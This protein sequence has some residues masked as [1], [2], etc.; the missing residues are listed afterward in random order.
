[1]EKNNPLVT[2][3]MQNGDIIKLELYPDIA[4]NTVNNFISLTR[5]GFYDGLKFHRV[6]RGFMIQ[7]GDP[8]GSGMGGPGYS[9]KGE[10]SYNQFENNVKH[11]AGVIS[12]ARSQRPNSAGSQ[13]FI[14]HKDS[15]HLDGSY[16]A[17]GKVIEGLDN[18]NK[19]AETKTDFSD[20]PLEPQI[21]K[22]V[23]VETFGV[24]YPEPE[25]C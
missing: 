6:I 17:F 20:A 24:D 15:P 2:I 7:G 25:T 3:E 14:M 23:T 19:I 21:M 5:K 12:M 11:T 13:F 22:K 1:M 9:I 16:A 8:E 4:P 10:F 18:V